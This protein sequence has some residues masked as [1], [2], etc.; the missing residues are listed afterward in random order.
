MSQ[1]KRSHRC[2]EWDYLLIDETCR[3]FEVCTC[4]QD[5]M[6]N[7]VVSTIAAADQAVKTTS[8]LNGLSSTVEVGE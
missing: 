8:G 2:P 6:W 7:N 5:E 1:A 4:F 3:E